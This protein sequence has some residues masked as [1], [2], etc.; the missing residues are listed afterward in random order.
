M[1]WRNSHALMNRAVPWPTHRSGETSAAEQWPAQHARLLVVYG[2]K[3]AAGGVQ[4]DCD[5]RHRMMPR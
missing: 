1:D 3:V 5:R 2:G 4:P